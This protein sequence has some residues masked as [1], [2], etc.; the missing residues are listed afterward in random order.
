M[1]T[2]IPLVLLAALVVG[3]G[4][5][6]G[7]GDKAGSEVQVTDQVDNTKGK[8]PMATMGDN[9]KTNAPVIHDPKEAKP[10]EGYKIAPANPDDPKYKADPRLSGGG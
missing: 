8:D 9:V 5:A 2:L 6:D 10:G 1:K 7:A 3:C 4:P